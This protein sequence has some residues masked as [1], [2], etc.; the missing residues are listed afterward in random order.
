MASL[1]SLT[2]QK[3]GRGDTAAEVQGGN[4]IKALRAN[5]TRDL[6]PRRKKYFIKVDSGKVKLFAFYY[7]QVSHFYS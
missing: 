4:A 2:T 1:K 5:V 7:H 6:I 3:K